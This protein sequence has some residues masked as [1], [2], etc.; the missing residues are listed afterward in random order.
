MKSNSQIRN[1]AV[2]VAVLLAGGILF[3]RS[4]LVRSDSGESHAKS[5]LPGEARSGPLADPVASQVG[6]IEGH[7]LAVAETQIIA[8]VLTS[9]TD[10]IRGIEQGN[11]KVIFDRKTEDGRYVV[12]SIP[13]LT[14]SEFSAV[15]DTLASGLL[16]SQGNKQ[17]RWEIRSQGEALIR[18]FLV[19]P[20]P[21]KILHV[22]SPT[23]ERRKVSFMEY[24]LDSEA[25]G[26][27]S[28]GG[29]FRLPFADEAV[30]RSDSKFGNKGSW[31]TERYS[32]LLGYFAH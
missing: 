24:F 20:K 32:H 15:N 22:Y 12:I 1:A 6:K 10:Q 31:A 26:T 17:L 18:R 14:D 27:P 25:R 11:R 13:R 3:C 28:A 9:L 8:E 4:L 19:Y 29:E 30:S 21:Y 16:K 7:E 23:D 5:S 2:I